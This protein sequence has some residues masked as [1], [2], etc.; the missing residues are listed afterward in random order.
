[1]LQGLSNEFLSRRAIET[2]GFA[3]LGDDVWI[4]PT[5]VI[6]NCASI[7][8]GSHVRI[9]PFCV[10]SAKRIDIS[11]HVNIASHS[12]LLGR[13]HV[14]IE[15]FGCVAPGARIL[16]TVDDFS[17]T[18]LVGPTIPEALRTARHGDVNICRHAIVGANSIVLA[19]TTIGEGSVVGALSLVNK[20]IAPW[21]I[22]VGIPARRIRDRSKG[23]LTAEASLRQLRAA[24]P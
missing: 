15:S 12:A 7:R 23:V 1:M 14:T 11:D 8:I 5:A 18:G 20:S 21:G 9:D 6:V 22:Y 17:G 24:T 3:E 10:L 16:T 4:H 2:L 13:C 19:G